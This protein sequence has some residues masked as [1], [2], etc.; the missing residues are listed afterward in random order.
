MTITQPLNIAHRGAS[1]EAPENT[2]AA[3]L[4][5]VEQGCDAIELDVHLSKDGE[6]VVC[7]DETIDRTTTGSG[8]IRDLTVAEL[9]RADAGVKFGEK[10]ASE[11][12]PL[13]EEVFAAMPAHMMI[14][15]ETKDTV[16]DGKVNRK[17]AELM[18]RANR[19]ENVVVSSFY[20]KSLVELVHLLPEAK[21]GL[22]YASD[23]ASHVRVA[24]A[25][26]VPVY[27]LH[28]NY[29]LLHASD[30]R[31][32]AERG[33]QMY[34]WTVNREETMRELIAAGVSGIINDYPARLKAL[35]TNEA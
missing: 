2:L 26:P 4:L 10:Y 30:I 35:L 29:R 27:S 32:A 13:L 22:L 25:V 1:G 12:L 5:A 3:F 15:V 17:L 11:R 21:I 16:F 8:A 28:P 18:N 23:F 14:N 6:L 33:I 20:H 24:D 7:H 31:E 34:P 9:K 19:V